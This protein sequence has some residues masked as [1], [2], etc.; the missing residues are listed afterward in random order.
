MVTEG[1]L[2]KGRRFALRAVREADVEIT[3]V[4]L[5]GLVRAVEAGNR[6]YCDALLRGVEVYGRLPRR[7]YELAR[8]ARA[9]SG[10]PP[11]AAGR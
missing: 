3:A 1:G 11:S 10:A 9:G 2:P 8:R 4:A 6:F 7:V 5:D